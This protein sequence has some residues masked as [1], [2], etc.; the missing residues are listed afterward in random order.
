MLWRS[1]KTA[2]RGG[3]GIGAAGIDRRAGSLQLWLVGGLLRVPRSS[4]ARCS[5][6]AHRAQRCGG[7][8]AADPHEARSPTLPGGRCPPPPQ[9]GRSL[10]LACSPSPALRGTPRCRSPSGAPAH[11][12][13]R[14]MP[15]APQLGRSLQLPCSPNPALRGTPRCRSR[16][17][18]L[19]HLPGG[20]CRRPDADR[21]SHAADLCP[22]GSAASIPPQWSLS[23]SFPNPSG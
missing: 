1:R 20:R 3:G 19:T 4:A 2:H 8:R 11:P 12:A 16:E 23:P 14:S 15:A 7:L 9:L 13:R 22:S 17:A 10:Q 18:R 6:P 5:S 21:E